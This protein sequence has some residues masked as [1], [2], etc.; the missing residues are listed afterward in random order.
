MDYRRT[1][2]AATFLSTSNKDS[3]LPIGYLLGEQ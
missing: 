3:T 2:G 1:S